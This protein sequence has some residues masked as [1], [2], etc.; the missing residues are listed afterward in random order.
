MMAEM[1]AKM[2]ANQAKMNAIMG[3]NQAEIRST[4]CTFSSELKE[5]VQRETKTVLHPIWAKLDETTTCREASQTELD[6]GMMQ[7]AEEHQEIPKGEAAVM[8]V[9]GLRKRIGSGCWPQSATRSQRKGPGDIV[10]HGKE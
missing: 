9:R 4:I 3:N 8:P 10:D 5:T 2:D 7:S 6:Q 1:T